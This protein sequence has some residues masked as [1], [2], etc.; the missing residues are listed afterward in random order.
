MMDERLAPGVRWEELTKSECFERLA[1]L[2][3][4]PLDPWAPGAKMYARRGR[5]LR[6]E[7]LG[8]IRSG[9]AGAR[10]AACGCR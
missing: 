4:L 1:R 6:R 8:V 2:R 3:K 9:P 7:A 5:R 10:D